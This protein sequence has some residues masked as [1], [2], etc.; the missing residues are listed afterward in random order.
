[1]NLPS[2]LSLRLVHALVI[3]VG[4]VTLYLLANFYGTSVESYWLEQRAE[5][6]RQEIARVERDNQALATQVARA[7]TEEY[8]ELIARE[9]LNMIRPGD[10]P[11]VMLRENQ[12][13]L[14]RAQ[15]LPPPPALP[16]PQPVPAVPTP[17]A[18]LGHVS[19]WLNLFFGS[20]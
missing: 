12:E 6:A 5:E 14:S 2:R 13:A 18:R 15:P 11:L 3:F 17:L 16:L 20:A 4:L 8:I 7:R 19:E 9:R 1:M 10:R